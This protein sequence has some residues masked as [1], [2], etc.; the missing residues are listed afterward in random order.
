MYV[1]KSP[2][3]GFFERV[4]LTDSWHNPFGSIRRDS[5]DYV[6]PIGEDILTYVL[7]VRPIIRPGHVSDEEWRVWKSKPEQI[8]DQD[9]VTIPQFTSLPK[10]DEIGSPESLKHVR[11]KMDVV[12]DDYAKLPPLGD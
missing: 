11:A 4:Y 1:T 10:I 2:R 8:V 12:D 3:R 5:G 7:L 6:L 9:V